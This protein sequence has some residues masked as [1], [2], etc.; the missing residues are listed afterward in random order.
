MREE[1][2]KQIHIMTMMTDTERIFLNWIPKEH[3]KL[4]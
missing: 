1:E 3:L 2:T 4:S